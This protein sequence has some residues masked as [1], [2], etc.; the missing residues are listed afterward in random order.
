MLVAGRWCTKTNGE[1]AGG[2]GE[3]GRAVQ[4]VNALGLIVIA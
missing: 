3:D 1:S 4:K 2:N